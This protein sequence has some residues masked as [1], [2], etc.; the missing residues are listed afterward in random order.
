MLNDYQLTQ[1]YP[2][3]A[4]YDAKGWHEM[5]YL[6]QGEFYSE[7]GSF[8]VSITL[9]ENYLVAGTGELQTVNELELLKKL[10][11]TKF[12]QQLNYK[13]EEVVV[14][15]KSFFPAKPVKKTKT[16]TVVRKT[17][18]IG[19]KTL[20]Y[21][22]ENVHDFAWFASKNFLV[23]YDTLQ[24][25][26]NVVDLFSFFHKKREK[27]GLNNIKHMKTALK[28]YSNW[29]GEYPYKTASVVIGKQ[30]K[31][32]GMEYPT[33]TYINTP[34]DLTNTSSVISHELGHIWLYGILASNERD[35]AW[36]D[37][38]MNT[39][40]DNKFDNEKKKSNKINKLVDVI[41]SSLFRIKKNMAIDTTSTAFPNMNYYGF[42]TY[43]DAANWMENLEQQLGKNVFD[44][45][46]KIYY[47]QWKFR[48]PYPNDFKNIVEEVSNKNLEEHFA[49]LHQTEN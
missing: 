43:L 8:D 16:E 14:E 13:I 30:E 11:K 2:K 3:P 27:N 5:P 38:G 20:H 17:K 26:N 48:H 35:H 23:Q 46:M 7:F 10:G 19:T 31:E 6:D 37:E 49:K 15:K 18:S 41:N 28:N 22:Q 24:L 42:K 12:N 4:V 29:L 21:H 44:S 45:C 34:N 33:I 1:W 40:Y 32:V 9:P 47:E 36:M 25:K 39:Y